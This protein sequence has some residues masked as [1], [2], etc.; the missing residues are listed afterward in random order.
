M[1]RALGHQVAAGGGARGEPRLRLRRPLPPRRGRRS[2]RTARGRWAP[3]VEKRGAR[4]KRSGLRRAP[5]ETPGAEGRGHS[6]AAPGPFRRPFP[7]PGASGAR[8]GSAPA[9]LRSRP[10]G[11]GRRGRAEPAFR[12]TA[13]RGGHAPGAAGAGAGAAAG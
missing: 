10:A 4:S 6:E 5:S 11:R 9:G 8:A 1:S 13:A 7:R 2:P 12:A 3:A